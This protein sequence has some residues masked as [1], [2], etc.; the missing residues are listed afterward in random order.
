MKDSLLYD[1]GILIYIVR[2]TSTNENVRKMVNPDGWKECISVVNKAEDLS[3]ANRNGWGKSKVLK[4]NKLF[5]SITIVD[6]SDDLI[7]DKYVEIDV[8]SQKQRGNKKEDSAKNMGKN[9]LWISATC[10]CLGLKLITTDK[11]YDHLQ[12]EFLE[13]SYFPPESFK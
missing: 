9:D 5:Q 4:L 3:I 7:I 11:D 13:R 1:T 8:F 6:I 12:N 10:S 2:D